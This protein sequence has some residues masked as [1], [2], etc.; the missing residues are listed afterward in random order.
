MLF[1]SKNPTF[2]IS[3]ARGVLESVFDECDRYDT[4]ET[5]GRLLGTYKQHKG[6]LDIDVR[7][8]LE[9]GPN[10]QRT[11]TFF[12]QDGDYQEKLFRAIE[13]VHPDVEHLGNWHTHHVNGLQTLSGG[14]KAT[15]TRVVNHVKHNT[16]FFYALLV[17]KKN[18][19]GNPRYE[20]KHFIFRRGDET[21]YE[22]PHAKVRLV[23][24]TLLQSCGNVE[25]CA[26]PRRNDAANL[27]R[28]KDQDFFSEFYPEMKVLL[29]KD[30][31]APYWKGSLS[32]ADGSRAEVVAVED[33]D[34]KARSYS[35][36]S[37]CKNPV[38]ADTL[39]KYRARKFPSARHAVLSL[40]RD[41]NHALFQ[42]KQG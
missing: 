40:E 27:Q 9:P 22:I 11:P 24:A 17:V 18:S 16:D 39:A 36:A 41:L 26:A 33:P 1:R 35:I 28:V 29:A 21:F 13:A 4:D 30:I 31:N 42:A 32:L 10:A 37:S 25:P 3:M 15:Y 38:L 2:A 8:I 6:R 12:L 7:G 34:D 5:G 23:D 19:G 14:D 20:V